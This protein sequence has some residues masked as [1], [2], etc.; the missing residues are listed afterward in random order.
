MWNF[1]TITV[2]VNEYVDFFN[3]YRPH[4]RLGYLTP[5]KVEEDYY[6]QNKTMDTSEQT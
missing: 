4:Q 2:H 1:I 6:S 3:D 5:N